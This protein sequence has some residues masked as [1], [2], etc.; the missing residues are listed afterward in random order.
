MTETSLNSFVRTTAF[1]ATL[2]GLFL[3]FEGMF[4]GVGRVNMGGLKPNYPA[5]ACE[6]EGGETVLRVFL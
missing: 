3:L 6:V 1:F 2:Y 5:W 4:V